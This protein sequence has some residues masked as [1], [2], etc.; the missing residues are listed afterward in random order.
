MKLSKIT[1]PSCVDCKNNSKIFCALS[2]NEKENLSKN[3]GGNFYKKGQAIFY[4]GNHSNG[5]YCIYKGKVKL[6]KLGE[7]GKEQVVR[8]AR[9]SDIIGY[10]ALLSNEPYQATAVA[11]EDCHVCHL[12]KEKFKELMCSNSNLSWNVM[13]LLSRDLKFAENHLINVAQKTVVERIAETLIVLKTTFGFLEDGKT[14]DVSLSRTEI[15]DVAGTTTE[16]TI[17]TLSNLAQEGYIDLDRKF[18]RILNLEG[19]IILAGIYD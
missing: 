9:T 18:I 4:E 13:R 2:I 10:R 16:T 17:R 15:A 14:L 19:L 3:K 1:I 6:S 11:L 8:F 5:L 12:S 7:R